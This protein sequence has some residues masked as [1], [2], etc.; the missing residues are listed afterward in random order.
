MDKDFYDEYLKIVSTV[1]EDAEKNIKR[2]MGAVVEYLSPESEL[3]VTKED[4]EAC[5][6]VGTDKKYYNSFSELL[7]DLTNEE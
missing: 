7:W 2:Y 3:I 1:G 4:I 6:N 5:L